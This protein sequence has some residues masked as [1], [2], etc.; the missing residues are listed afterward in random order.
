M[1]RKEKI[2]FFSFQ[3]HDYYLLQESKRLMNNHS[4]LPHNCLL[5]VQAGNLMLAQHS[6]YGH[7]EIPCALL[8]VRNGGRD[9]RGRAWVGMQVDKLRIS[10]KGYEMPGLIGAVCTR[11]AYQRGA[12]ENAFY[13]YVNVV[14]ELL[15]MAYCIGSASSLAWSATKTYCRDTLEGN[16]RLNLWA[17]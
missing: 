5:H 12:G 17:S 14:V 4:L 7:K 15:E 16:L 10:W 3:D 9:S 6:R 2:I 1:F 8:T 13:I 11:N